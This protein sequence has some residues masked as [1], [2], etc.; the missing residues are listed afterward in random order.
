ME[1][2]MLLQPT[3]DLLNYFNGSTFVLLFVSAI[4]ESLILREYIMWIMG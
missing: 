2:S 1:Q 4:I 3:N